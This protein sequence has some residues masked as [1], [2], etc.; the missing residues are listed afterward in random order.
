[1]GL[2]LTG[3]GGFGVEVKRVW[4]GTGV[5]FLGGFGYGVVVPHPK[6]T[7][8]PSLCMN[9]YPDMIIPKSLICYS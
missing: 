9:V 1:M 5:D 7:P 8:L 3:L 6:P 2:S 4:L